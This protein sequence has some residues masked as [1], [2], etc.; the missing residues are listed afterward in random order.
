MDSTGDDV[1]PSSPMQVNRRHPGSKNKQR[2][3]KRYAVTTQASGRMYQPC[4]VSQP[5]GN[6]ALSPNSQK[7]TTTPAIAVVKPLIFYR[8]GCGFMGFRPG[9]D[10]L[11]ENQLRRNMFFWRA[12]FHWRSILILCCQLTLKRPWKLGKK[13]K[14]C[15]ALQLLTAI[16]Q[17][18]S[19]GGETEGNL[20]T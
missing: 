15:F 19:C 13:Q 4:R 18:N 14:D 7:F 6:A 12:G 5:R 11:F 10:Q 20:T 1:Y 17:F 9:S 3:Y 2:N 16:I 8:I